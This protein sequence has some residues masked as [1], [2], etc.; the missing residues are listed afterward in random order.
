MIVR[1]RMRMTV[2]LAV[3]M[4]VGTGSNRFFADDTEFRRPDACTD[5]LL[6]PHRFGCNGET[7]EST[8]DVV[9]R[10]AG[11]DQGAEHHV[12]GGTREAVEVQNPH[13]QPSYLLDVD[14]SNPGAINRCSCASTGQLT[15]FHERVV[16]LVG[17]DQV[18]E[19]FDADDLTRIG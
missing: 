5:D 18:I 3:F 4:I 2:A 7:P 11:V 17:E 6:R 10:H 16:S 15:R 19:H 1:M 9:E 12:T 8:A 14:R 13:N